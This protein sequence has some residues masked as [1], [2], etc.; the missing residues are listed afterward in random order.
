[1]IFPNLKM[2]KLK[3]R[4][5]RHL[6]K[7]L[8]GWNQDANPGDLVWFPGLCLK[9]LHITHLPLYAWHS[10]RHLSLPGASDPQQRNRKKEHSQFPVNSITKQ[11]LPQGSGTASQTRDT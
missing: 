1:M 4:T 8:L 5:V 6:F 11:A 9:P 10:A 2:R 3:H 7:V